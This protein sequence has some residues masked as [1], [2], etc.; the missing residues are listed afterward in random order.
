[1]TSEELRDLIAAAG[2]N[3]PCLAYCGEGKDKAG[4]YLHSVCSD[5]DPRGFSMDHTHQCLG[6]I[7][8]DTEEQASAR[9]H[10]IAHALNEIIRKASE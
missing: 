5:E 4:N 8:G 7:R 10:L 6:E 3:N 1:M 2:I 9:A